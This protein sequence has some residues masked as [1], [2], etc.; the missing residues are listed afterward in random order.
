MMLDERM[1][2][3]LFVHVQRAP[4]KNV[5]FDLLRWSDSEGRTDE[6]VCTAHSEKPRNRKLRA[7]SKELNGEVTS[8]PLLE[9]RNPPGRRYAMRC[10]IGAWMVVALLE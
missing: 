4:F 3:A 8:P 5:V 7:L 6:L 1:N 10:A 2:V 9:V